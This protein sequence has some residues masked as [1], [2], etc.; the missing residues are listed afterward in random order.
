MAFATAT[1]TGTYQKLDGSP[2]EGT[3][4]IIPNSRALVDSEGNVILSGRRTV[5]LDETGS[6]SVVLPATD[7]ATVEPAVGRQYTVSAKPRHTRH[8]PAVEGI[9]LP[10]GSTRDM[11]DI[12]TATALT[13]VV[14]GGPSG[15]AFLA[16]IDQL[17][18]EVDRA[19]AAEEAILDGHD[20]ATATYITT[21]GTATKAALSA[22]YAPRSGRPDLAAKVAGKWWVDRWVTDY[23]DAPPAIDLPVVSF[24]MGGTSQITSKATHRE[25]RL[26][27]VSN[28]TVDWNGDPKFRYLGCPPAAVQ[29]MAAAPTQFIETLA[30]PGG[31][32]Q[33]R[34]YDLMIETETSAPEIEWRCQVA[35][36]GAGPMMFWVNGRWVSP[37]SLAQSTSAG[38]MLTKLTFPDARPRTIRAL[39]PGGVRF[40]GCYATPGH[41]VKRVQNV[42]KRRVCVIADSMG[43]STGE[44]PDGGRL[45]DTLQYHLPYLLGADETLAFGIG[46]TKWV[47]AG[48][49][50]VAV[51]H[52]GGDRLTAALALNPDVIVFFGS[53]N[54]SAS[55]QPQLDAIQAAVQSAL[56]LC[57][58]VP[59]VYV[60]GT[61]TDLPQNAVVKAATLAMG[62]TFVDLKGI[63]YGTGK[64][65]SPTGDGNADYYLR[66]EATPVH[67]TY[68]GHRHIVR[69]FYE[70]I[71]GAF[72]M[73]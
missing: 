55:T 42:I 5:T 46:G 26:G 54:D 58:N 18:A 6:F 17:A 28:A 33:A 40:G 50:D 72:G 44:P 43:T 69:K 60:A 1:L 48:S 13:P 25:A 52:F 11:A 64:Y 62:R 63:V 19:T 66:S 38:E 68:L 39:L 16:L 7:D 67:P 23:L 61:I 35:N 56:T 3:V 47:A 71:V 29:P 10:G 59:E 45:V 49:G 53:R 51:S 9:E 8:I 70:G 4:D 15:A 34:K 32:S 41:A 37:T 21:N 12:T 73:S 27:G 24:V 36:A 2:A 20:A 22:A 30:M 31:A 14:S 65:G 57:A